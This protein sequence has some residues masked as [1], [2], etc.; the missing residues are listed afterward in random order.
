MRRRDLQ[1]AV[2]EAAHFFMA[3][4]EL[5]N[6]LIP[7]NAINLADIRALQTHAERLAAALEPI[8]AQ[9]AAACEL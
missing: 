6:Q 9:A 7:G 5:A 8:T 3:G 1:K 4:N 2:A